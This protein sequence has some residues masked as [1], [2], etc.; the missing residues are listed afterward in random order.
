MAHLLILIQIVLSCLRQLIFDYIPHILVTQHFLNCFNLNCPEA[1]TYVDF[2]EPSEKITAA[3][4]LHFNAVVYMLMISSG[5]S[6]TI[7]LTHRFII[8]VLVLTELHWN[9]SGAMKLQLSSIE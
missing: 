7:D 1:P 6:Q 4:P 8:L 9:K 3:C 2:L 5:D